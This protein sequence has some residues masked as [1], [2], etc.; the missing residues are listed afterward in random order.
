MDTLKLINVC[1]EEDKQS[2]KD[3]ITPED[4]IY[5]CNAINCIY[6]T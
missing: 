5:N 1:Q 6:D 4:K 3:G 2:P